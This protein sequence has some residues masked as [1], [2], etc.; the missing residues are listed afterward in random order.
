MGVRD[1]PNPTLRPAWGWVVTEQEVSGAAEDD[2]QET[3]LV[4]DGGTP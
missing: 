3:A 4:I 2:T 1:V